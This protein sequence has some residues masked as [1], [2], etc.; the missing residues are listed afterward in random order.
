MASVA[1]GISPP[2]RIMRIA[3]FHADAF[4]TAQLTAEGE[5]IRG[6]M[7]VATVAAHSLDDLIV[8]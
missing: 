5:T 2:R 1:T 4:S 7:I 6:N 8:E 3:Q